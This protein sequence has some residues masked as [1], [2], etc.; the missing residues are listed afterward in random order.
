MLACPV[1]AGYISSQIW[2]NYTAR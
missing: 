2:I 1:D